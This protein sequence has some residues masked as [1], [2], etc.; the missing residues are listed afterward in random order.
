MKRILVSLPTQEVEQSSPT[1]NGGHINTERTRLL[2]SQDI[3]KNSIDKLSGS[4]K[5]LPTFYR[6]DF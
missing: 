6:C 4:R 2:S 5:R 1:K 3:R